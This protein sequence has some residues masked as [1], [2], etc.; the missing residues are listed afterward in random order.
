MISSVSGGMTLGRLLDALSQHCPSCKLKVF[1]KRIVGKYV[2]ERNRILIWECP[3]CGA[4]W[5]HPRRD[6]DLGEEE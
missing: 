4:L 2:R 3:D 6:V 1:A 5:Q